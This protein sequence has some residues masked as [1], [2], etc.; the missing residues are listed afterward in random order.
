VSQ[1]RTFLVYASTGFL[2]QGVR[3]AGTFV[4]R[5]IADPATVGII[6]IAQLVAPIF[7]S[8]TSG[9]IYRALRLLPGQARLEQATTLW[10]FLIGN[11]IEVG[12]I[13]FPFT[14]ACFFALPLPP[15]ARL[16]LVFFIVVFAFGE[17]L[18]GIIESMFMALPRPRFIAQCRLL[19]IVELSLALIAVKVMGAPGYLTMSAFFAV[20]AVMLAKRQV[21]V[22][23]L[24]CAD[25]FQALKINQY[26]SRIAAEKILSSL[27]SVLDGL[28]VTIV[29]GPV[30]LA[31]YSLGMVVRGSIGGMS[32]SLYWALWPKGVKDHDSSKQ[33]QFSNQRVADIYIFVVVVVTLASGAIV[34]FFV[35][36]MLQ[37]YVDY[38]PV[39]MLVIASTVPMA[40]GDW[41]RSGL[42]VR[43]QAKSLPWITL[44]RIILFFVCVWGLKL[45][46]FS[47]LMTIAW[48]AFYVYL[49]YMIAITIIG[50]REQD[51]WV[52]GRELVIRI[53]SCGIPLVLLC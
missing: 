5:I 18:S 50:Y 27:A 46:G 7:S 9:L 42:I 44:W 24:V 49:F 39:I 33:S 38:L 6:N 35:K 47:T 15:S 25:I 11:M 8:L 45:A 28:V 37:G 19:D 52:M 16:V 26:G 10:S 17:R 40:I 4:L 30:K 1:R 43:E 21:S 14:L 20:I 34:Q 53:I 3:F 2:L 29:C 13:F 31:G 36:K 48:V 32:N 51:A 12:L 41:V 22:P 23:E